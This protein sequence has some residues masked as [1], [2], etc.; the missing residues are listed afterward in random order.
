MKKLALLLSLVLLLACSKEEKFPTKKDL[1]G[2]WVFYDGRRITDELFFDNKSI[3]F[4]P[5]SENPKTLNY[6]LDIDRKRIYFAPMLPGMIYD[7]YEIWIDKGTGWLYLSSANNP[8]R[9]T[10]TDHE[11]IYKK[12]E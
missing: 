1:K 12:K 11:S 6:R 8:I 10:G 4:N 3:Q 2:Y 9:D 7:T 5:H